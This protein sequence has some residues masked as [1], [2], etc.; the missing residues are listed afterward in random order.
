MTRP[1][2]GIRLLE[3]AVRYALTAAAGVTPEFLSR[4]TP[5]RGWDLRMLLL[6]AGESLDAIYEG[7]DAGCVSLHPAACDADLAA[8][9]ADP[10]RA[11][12]DRA[13]RL[14]DGWA[15]TGRAH[16][17]RRPG[18][19]QIAD[20]LVTAAALAG[21][22]A[23]EIAVHGWDI[24][25]ACGHGQPIPRDLAAGLLALAPQLVPSTRHP[26]FAAPVSVAPEAGASDQ[27]TAFL[28]RAGVL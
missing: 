13:S 5:C 28:G 25:Q 11:F 26:L 22:G 10:A 4:P 27:L 15:S 12:R 6:H 3:P 2:E 1:P 24:S 8:M 19:I 17:G 16:T 21:A 9:A 18:L 23:L 7:I 20:R 14:L